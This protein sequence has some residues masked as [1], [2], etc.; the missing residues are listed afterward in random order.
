MQRCVETPVYRQPQMGTQMGE[1]MQAIKRDKF[2]DVE[3]Q[4]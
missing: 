2:E 1:F 4:V 3:H